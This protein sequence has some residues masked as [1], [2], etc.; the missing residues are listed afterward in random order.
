MNHSCPSSV[1]GSIG[2]NHSPTQPYSDLIAS[3][4]FRDCNTLDVL[5]LECNPEGKYWE[6]RRAHRLFLGELFS[7]YICITERWIMRHKTD[8]REEL[9]NAILDGARE[10]HLQDPW[11]VPIASD[12]RVTSDSLLAAVHDR[13]VSIMR[14][15]YRNPRNGPGGSDIIVEIVAIVLVKY[16]L[17][18]SRQ[19]SESGRIFALL[20][21]RLRDTS[22]ELVATAPYAALRA[23]GTRASD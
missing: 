7:F 22:H 6:R 1:H 16:F 12:R 19:T 9:L 5:W 17:A 3:A 15:N 11:R 21:N 14:N 20:V 8:R 18:G 2:E 13:G 4:A 23:T 10:K